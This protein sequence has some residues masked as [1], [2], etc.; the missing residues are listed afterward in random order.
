MS[1]DK[2]LTTRDLITL[3]S[4]MI[5]RIPQKDTRDRTSLEFV[6]SGGWEEG[7]TKTTK[8]T[9]MVIAWKFVVENLSRGGRLKHLR[10]KDVEKIS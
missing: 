9:K 3:V 1:R 10:G 5:G 2:Y 6:Y 4:P 7:K 8:N